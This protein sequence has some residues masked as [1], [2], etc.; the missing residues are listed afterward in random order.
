MDTAQL[1]IT[2]EWEQT[3]LDGDILRYGGN[4]PLYCSLYKAFKNPTTEQREYLNNVNEFNMGWEIP[5]KMKWWAEFK[6]S[7]D[8]SGWAAIQELEKRIKARYEQHVERPTMFQFKIM[9]RFSQSDYNSVKTFEIE[10]SVP[11]QDQGEKIMKEAVRRAIK[12]VIKTPDHR[13]IL[14]LINKNRRSHHE[15]LQSY[16]TR[17][18]GPDRQ[19]HVDLGQEFGVK[20]DTLDLACTIAMQY[21][22]HLYTNECEGGWQDIYNFAVLRPGV[23]EEQ[24]F[25]KGKF[26]PKKLYS[27]CGGA[28]WRACMRRM[29]NGG[30]WQEDAPLR[31]INEREI[32]II[33]M[34]P[35]D[36]DNIDNAIRSINSE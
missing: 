19:I 27:I 26:K 6:W 24:Y 34:N 11:L 33:G 1:A 12:R 35:N 14:N 5:F 15:R 32:E 13:R 22:E 7:I 30:Q 25:N 10:P 16:W 8:M 21:M 31:E 23:N 17:I 4:P 29:Q 18:H 3:K 9:D 36:Q 28:V 20:E 2:Y